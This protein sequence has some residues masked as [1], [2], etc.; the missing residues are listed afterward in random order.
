M[1]LARSPRLRFLVACQVLACLLTSACAHIEETQTYR[2]DPLERARTS[3][4]ETGLGLGVTGSR[5]GPA[6]QAQV[7]DVTWCALEH[8]Q[9]ARG[10]KRVERVPVGQSLTIEWVFGGLFTATSAGLMTLNTLSPPEN[11]ELTMRSQSSGYAFAGVVGAIGLGLLTGA[12][13]QQASLGRHD[14]DM[15]VKEMV[16]RDNDFVCKREPAHG[17]RVRLTL[18]D[19]MQLEA[20]ADQ[21]GLAVL[22]LPGDIESRLA[23]GRR[24]TLEAIGDPRAQVRIPL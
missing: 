21:N 10:W 11:P 9:R 22:L 23:E 13:V 12:I 18:A 2:I 1:K 7:F 24:A 19:G 6:V 8:K 20:D 5:Q 17:G 15:G 3:R 16:K 4:V 14:T